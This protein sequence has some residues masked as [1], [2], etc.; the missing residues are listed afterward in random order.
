MAAGRG[1]VGDGVRPA[2]AAS[3][4]GS[5]TQAGPPA[6]SRWAAVRVRPPRP[7]H[8]PRRPILWACS[9]FRPARLRG[10]ATRT[11]PWAST[12]S[13]TR[14]T[15]HP[16]RLRKSRF[17]PGG[18]SCPRKSGLDQRRRLTAADRH[19]PLRH[20]ERRDQRVRR[21]QQCSRRQ[22]GAVDGHL[23]LGRRRRGRVGSATGLPGQRPGR[24]H[25]PG[26]RLP[27]RRT[28]VLGRD[29]RH[30]PPPRPCSC[31]RSR[32]STPPPRRP[33]RCGRRCTAPGAVA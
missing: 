10:P 13:S 22:F 12:P 15:S 14:S 27:G 17:T 4:S 32:R 19:R 11:P 5:S 1:G 26:R 8:P 21:S 33:R 2:A 18:D 31:S 16:P 28:R 25:R 6:S 29:P 3:A 24:H 20:R 30:P 9:R 23:R 7:P